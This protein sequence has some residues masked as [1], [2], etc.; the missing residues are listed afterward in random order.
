MFMIW[1]RRNDFLSVETHL[2]ICNIPAYAT[3]GLLLISYIRK[4]CL[5]SGLFFMFV[6]LS[7][8]VEMVGEFLF[9]RA[10]KLSICLMKTTSKAGKAS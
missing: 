2:D 3:H 5:D 4:Y 1:R 6:C 7:K 9:T 8:M 10:E